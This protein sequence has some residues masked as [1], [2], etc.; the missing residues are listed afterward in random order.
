MCQFRDGLRRRRRVGGRQVDQARPALLELTGGMQ[1]GLG[2]PGGRGL[3]RLVQVQ[4]QGLA[5]RPQHGV[6][7]QIGVHQCVHPAPGH[8]RPE[9]QRRLERVQAAPLLGLP[10]PDASVGLLRRLPVAVRLP[11]PFQEP[12]EGVV[13]TPA[14]RLHAGVVRGAR[15]LGDLG[16]DR[17]FDLLG[18]AGEER[19][20]VMVQTR[21]QRRERTAPVIGHHGGSLRHYCDD[22]HQ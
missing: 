1:P 17:P 13:H 8:P 19:S 9:P 21:E 2:V 16:P 5:E 10:A 18:D 20:E 11:H 7:Q 6:R 12:V 15:V 22:T 3:G 14:H 4:E